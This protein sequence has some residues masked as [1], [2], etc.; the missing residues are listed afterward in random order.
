ME[1]GL[2]LRDEPSNARR[3]A[4]F[5]GRVRSMPESGPVADRTAFFGLVD[6]AATVRPSPRR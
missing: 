6:L 2:L 4:D 3:W 5:L 1:F